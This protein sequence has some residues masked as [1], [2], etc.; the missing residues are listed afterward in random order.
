MFVFSCVP[1]ILHF[2]MS[3]CFWFKC[4]TRGAV[5][6]LMHRGH[7]CD[8]VTI[9]GIFGDGVGVILGELFFGWG[10]ILVLAGLLGRGVAAIFLITFI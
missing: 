10:V 8:R 7:L 1:H 2:R 4:C 9:F 5:K 3:L 6:S